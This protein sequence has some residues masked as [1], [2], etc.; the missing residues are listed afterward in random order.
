[1]SKDNKPVVTDITSL[2]LIKNEIDRLSKQSFSTSGLTL[3][4]VKKLEILIKTR[5]LVLGEPTEITQNVSDD[6]VSDED[7]LKALRKP[8]KSNGKEE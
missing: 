2:Q 5:Q 4:D 8:K 1:M 6:K 3:E 7:I